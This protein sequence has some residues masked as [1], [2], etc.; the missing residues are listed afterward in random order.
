[1][2]R[3]NKD[4][5]QLSAGPGGVIASAEDLAK[6]VRMLLHAGV[7]PE[8][9]ETIIPKTAFE[10][11][12]TAHAVVDGK[13]TAEK[14]IEGYGMGW[15]RSSYHGHNIVSHSGGNNDVTTLVM[16]APHDRVGLVLLINQESQLAVMDI[17]G[18]IFRKAFGIPL[19]DP[20][21][22][23]SQEKPLGKQETNELE[24]VPAG[25]TGTYHSA[26]QGSPVTFY[27]PSSS[28]PEA[29]RV[30]STFRTECGELAANDLYAALPR[31]WCTHIHLVHLGGARF[32]LQYNWFFPEGYGKDK[33][34]FALH[35]Q[36]REY[37]AVQFEIEGERVVGF[38]LT[39]TAGNETVLQRR[40]GRLQESADAWFD[41]V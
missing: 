14:S 30:L 2:T 32:S 7:D 29:E 16:F 11:V 3:N 12:T 28:G 23:T 4:N 10:D 25:L 37:G 41:R 9:G 1:M 19:G 39:G 6:W 22:P 18:A 5:Y 21:K 31:A 15:G 26:G 36:D 17:G 8:S 33:S 20:P 35:A 38:G 40:A 27:S 24:P 34:P 13:G